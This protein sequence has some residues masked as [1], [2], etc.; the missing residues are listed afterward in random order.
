MGIELALNLFAKSV[1]NAIN[2]VSPMEL[3]CTCTRAQESGLLD[4][5][6]AHFFCCSLCSLSG[7]Q[8]VVRLL[9]MGYQLV[10]RDLYSKVVEAHMKFRGARGIRPK[11]DWIQKPQTE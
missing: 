10:D 11:H 2:S 8:D 7:A 1:T 5:C 6:E 3:A 9:A 4:R